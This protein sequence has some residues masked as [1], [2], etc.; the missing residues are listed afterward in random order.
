MKGTPLLLI[1]SLALGACSLG[2][3]FTRP[4]RPAPGDWSLQA[5]A[6]NPS[7]L[8]AAPL[9]AQWWT[10][11]D[12]AQLNALLQRVQRAN[13]DLRSAAALRRARRDP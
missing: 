4:D 13:L 9:A 6:G 12:D 3:D 5:A 8:A 11:F 10:L 1:A 7:H 2:P